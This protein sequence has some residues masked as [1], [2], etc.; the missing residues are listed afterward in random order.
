MNYIIKNGTVVNEGN[1]NSATSISTTASW[2][3]R[4]QA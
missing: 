3:R 1:W 4:A 2:W